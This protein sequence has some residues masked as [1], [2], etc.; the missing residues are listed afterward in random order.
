MIAKTEGFEEAPGHS[1]T[2]CSHGSLLYSR[3]KGG[4]VLQARYEAILCRVHIFRLNP[5]RATGPVRYE[6]ENITLLSEEVFILTTIIVKSWVGQG[7]GR[8][9]EVYLSG[10]TGC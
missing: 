10:E 9:G 8:K 2:S 5:A 4:D 1:Q 7:G 6:G 3:S